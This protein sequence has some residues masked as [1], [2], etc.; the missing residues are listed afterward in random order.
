M[1]MVTVSTA[2]HRPRGMV[3]VNRHSFFSHDQNTKLTLYFARSYL[4]FHPLLHSTAQVFV[5]LGS[6]LKNWPHIQ[7]DEAVAVPASADSM[8]LTEMRMA[9][10]RR[11]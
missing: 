8:P 5:L 1:T 2:A 11:D 7:S 4:H 6:H 3:A 9:K 10:L